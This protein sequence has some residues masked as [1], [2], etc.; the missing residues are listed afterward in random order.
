MTWWDRETESIW[1]QPWGRALTGPLK[2]TQLQAIPFSLVP[3]ETWRQSHPDTLVLFENSYIYGTE[4]ISDDFVAG[5]A[6]GDAA[7]AYPYEVLAESVVI[8]DTLNEIPLVVHT[9]PDT[10]S[11]HFYIRQI[12]DGTLLTFSGDA[13]RLVDDLTGSIWNPEVGV[14]M[15]GELAG[16]GLREL[17]YV[18]SFDW[19]WLD[20]Y[21]HSD[22]YPPN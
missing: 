7:R 14:A 9:N 21:P 8:N 15:E 12:P 6:I 4:S 11:I 18:S 2:G 5:L 10:R 16:Q 1:T 17:P 20:F 3:W 19:A 13:V 22:F